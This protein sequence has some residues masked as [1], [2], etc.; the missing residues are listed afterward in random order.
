VSPKTKA[1]FI[2]SIANPGG[3]ITDIEAVANIARRAG[4]P[5]IVDNTLASPYLVR[6]IE[7]GADIVVHALTKFIGGHGNSIGGII[8]DGGTFDWSKSG[9]YPLLSQPRADYG[10]MV[11]HETFGNFA[12]AIACRVLALRD[13]GPALS[14]FN[15]FLVLTGVETLPLRMQRHCDNANAVS[16]WLSQH[17]NVA[18]VSYPGLAGDRYHNLAKK[19]APKGA[20]AVFTFGLKGGYD[21]GVKLVSNVKLFSHLANIGDTRSLIIHPA[22][23]THRQLSDAQKVQAGA[24]PDVV[25]LSI[26]L[27]DKDDIIADLEQALAAV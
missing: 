21:A 20:G 17:A 23:T 9:K 27:E 22:S 4:V 6:P 16:H 5:L 1:I 25:R 11:L 3:V 7:H 14:P 8:V 18:W 19:Y 26:G 10:G 24:G 12:F 2:E 15:A 13:I